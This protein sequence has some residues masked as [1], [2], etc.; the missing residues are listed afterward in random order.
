MLQFCVVKGTHSIGFQETANKS[1]NTNAIGFTTGFHT[2]Q[3][4]SEDS[5]PMVLLKKLLKELSLFLEWSCP[6][7]SQ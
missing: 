7:D 3:W 4:D 1:S 6:Q 2:S 5:H